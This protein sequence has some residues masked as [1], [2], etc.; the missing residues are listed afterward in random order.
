MLGWPR[1]W[2]IKKSSG[3]KVINIKKKKRQ[4]IFSEK[5]QGF[6]VNHSWI[7][8][9]YRT[10]FDFNA[11]ARSSEEG[12]NEEDYLYG[13]FSRCPSCGQPLVRVCGIDARFC[14]GAL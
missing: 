11:S 5:I 3:R 8:A 14:R 1:G 9:F 7:R 4:I 10:G 13:S 2:G 6:F 12:K